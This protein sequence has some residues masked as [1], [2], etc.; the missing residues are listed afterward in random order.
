MFKMFKASLAWAVPDPG[1]APRWGH[2][3]R[4]GDPTYDFAIYIPKNSM[5]NLEPGGGGASKILLCRS[6]TDE[7]NFY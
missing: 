3:P 2:Q 6:A 4:G 1:F 7:G 5:K